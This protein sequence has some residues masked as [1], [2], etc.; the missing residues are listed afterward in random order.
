VI[1]AINDYRIFVALFV[2]AGFT[3]Q[4]RHSQGVYWCN[5]TQCYGLDI[6]LWSQ[7][8]FLLLLAS[9]HLVSSP[10]SSVQQS[11]IYYCSFRLFLF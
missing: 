11:F 4:L 8:L 7:E 10:H 5:R 1:H 6:V 9:S 3:W 2:A